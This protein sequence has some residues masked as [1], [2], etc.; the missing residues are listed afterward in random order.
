MPE[1]FTA[2][3][4]GTSPTSCRISLPVVMG[5]PDL[6]YVG[7]EPLEWVFVMTLA[8]GCK[9]SRYVPKFKGFE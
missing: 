3:K 1:F 2:F 9:V 5:N 6:G 7:C 8:F 4:L